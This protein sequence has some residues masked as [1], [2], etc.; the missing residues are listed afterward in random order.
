ML[1][2]LILAYDGDDEEALNRRMAVR[3]SH[4]EMAKELKMH[5]RFVM[6]GAILDDGGLMIGSMMVVQ[7][8]TEDDLLHWMKNEPYI[9]GDVWQRIEVK[10][11]RVA[12]V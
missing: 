2:Y 8:E 6:G 10:P 1:Q 9:T 5:D 3:P 7:F 12:E 11:F 4:F